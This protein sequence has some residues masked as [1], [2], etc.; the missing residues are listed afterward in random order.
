[1]ELVDPGQDCGGPA[2]HCPTLALQGTEDVLRLS[3]QV[4][5]LAHHQGQGGVGD[6]LELVLSVLRQEVVTVSA[7]ADNP[8]NTSVRHSQA[9]YNFKILSSSLSKHDNFC[10]LDQMF[11]RSDLCPDQ[12]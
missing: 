9:F 6:E 12:L 7:R 5:H 3:D 1:M 2:V 11:S 8:A 10:P 4:G